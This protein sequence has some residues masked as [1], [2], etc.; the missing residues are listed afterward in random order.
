MSGSVRREKI[1]RADWR[2]Y[3][4]ADPAALLPHRVASAPGDTPGERRF[5]ALREVVHAALRGGAG[6]VQLRDKSASGR[7]LV[8]YGCALKQLCAGFGALFVVN[9]RVDVALACGADGVHLGPEDIDVAQARRI[10]PELV[11]GASSGD[12]EVAKELVSAG[13]DYLGVGAIYE[14]R[15][16]KADASAPRGPA[17]L[18]EVRAAVGAAVPVVGI[19]GIDLAS[20]AEV[21]AHGASGVAVIRQVVGADAPELAVRALWT[22]VDAAR[23]TR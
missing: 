17:V 1:D 6:V 15:P 21:A 3:V 12:A 23:G 9:D 8:A 13:A 14:A 22:A 11:I 18:R 20:A 10:A 2:V 5:E 16:S 4:V 7:E 19:G